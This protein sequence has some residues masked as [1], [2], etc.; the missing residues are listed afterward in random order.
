MQKPAYYYF[1]LPYLSGRFFLSILAA[2]LFQVCAVATSHGQ[3]FGQ[4]SAEAGSQPQ[5][6]KT[7]ALAPGEFYDKELDLHFNYPVEMDLVDWATAMESGHLAIYGVSGAGDPEHE[8]ARKCVRPLL[9]AELPAEKA[10]KRVPDLS[11][12]WVE[13]SEE[14]SASPQDKAI[15]ASVYI[16]EIQ[17]SCIPKDA[18]KKEDAAPSGIALGFVSAPGLQKMPAPWWYE[19]GKQK[20]HMNSSAGRVLLPGGRRTAPIFIMS[21]ATSWQGHLLAWVFT[22]NDTKT[23]NEI[24]KSLV[25]FGNNPWSPMFAPNVGPKGTGTPVNVLPK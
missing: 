18:R 20:I 13:D 21:M 11:D 22:S 4:P 14:H 3:E 15:S 6:E 16:V 9:S 19:L 2:I 5:S 25:R 24:T 12:V 1:L 17:R 10:P 8:Q 7:S 23:F